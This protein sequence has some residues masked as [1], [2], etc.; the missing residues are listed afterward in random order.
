MRLFEQGLRQLADVEA[1][2]RDPQSAY[3]I[4]IRLKR[5]L[6]SCT[7]TLAASQGIEKPDL[8]SRVEELR[9][10]DNLHDIAIAI[11]RIQ[12]LAEHLCQPSEALDVR[13]QREWA[14]LASEIQRLEMLLA[15]PRKKRLLTDNAVNCN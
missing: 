3:L 1:A 5:A 9:R 13:W 15:L 4:R 11:N 6:L 10:P 2:A 7:R 12:Y 14:T 8:L